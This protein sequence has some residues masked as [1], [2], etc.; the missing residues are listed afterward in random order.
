MQFFVLFVWVLLVY[1]LITRTLHCSQHVFSL[2][3]LFVA[4][5]LCLCSDSTERQG[6]GNP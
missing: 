4:F 3:F 2:F 5:W 6:F 1:G